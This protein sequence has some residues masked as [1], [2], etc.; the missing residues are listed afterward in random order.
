MTKSL[1][2]FENAIKAGSVLITVMLFLWRAEA[3]INARIDAT[4]EAITAQN[5]QIQGQL[6]SVVT[7]QEVS[8]VRY[9][10]LLRRLER[11]ESKME[12]R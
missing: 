8:D 5:Q 9:G 6:Q 4:R 3:N 1:L 10:E 11:L 12:R 2:T 7:R